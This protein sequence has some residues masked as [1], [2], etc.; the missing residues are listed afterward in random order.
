MESKQRMIE[1]TRSQADALP[2]D[3]SAPPVF[4][5][6]DRYYV[7]ADEWRAYVSFTSTSL[8]DE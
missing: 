5:D 1:I 2:K 3:L 6:G 4:R 8:G 7:A